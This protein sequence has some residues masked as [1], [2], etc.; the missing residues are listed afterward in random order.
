MAQLTTADTQKDNCK[1]LPYSNIVYSPDA[2]CYPLTTDAV[3]SVTQFEY[4]YQVEAVDMTSFG[5]NY[6][7]SATECYMELGL[8]C[9]YEATDAVISTLTLVEGTICGW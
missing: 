7:D 5:L 6:T 2:V 4:N 8:I 3:T 1:Y 9:D